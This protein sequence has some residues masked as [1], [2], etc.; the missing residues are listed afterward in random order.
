MF[1]IIDTL[2]YLIYILLSLYLSVPG[3]HIVL[4]RTEQVP[5]QHGLYSALTL[6]IIIV[7][8]LTITIGLVSKIDIKQF[9]S[10]F[11]MLI[12][13]LPISAL[14]LA[15]YGDYYYGFMI[16]FPILLL[17]SRYLRRLTGLY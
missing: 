2:V 1:T 6:L 16:V 8:G 3:L 7:I 5:E 17:I 9:V 12:V 10:L 13:M 11:L 14:G 4:H 15:G